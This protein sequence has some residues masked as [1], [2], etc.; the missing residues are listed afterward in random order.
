MLSRRGGRTTD[1]FRRCRLCASERC[2]NWTARTQLPPACFSIS[3]RVVDEVASM[4]T[5]SHDCQSVARMTESPFGASE[6]VHYY[7]LLIA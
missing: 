6:L 1:G 2:R 4:Q 7:S 5:I 3:L